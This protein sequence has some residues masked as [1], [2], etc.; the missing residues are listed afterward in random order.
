MMMVI[1][2]T[3]QVVLIRI[4]FGRSGQVKSL[5]CDMYWPLLNGMQKICD[6][7]RGG[8]ILGGL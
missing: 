8:F 2:A 4:V 1:L 7:G 6:L 5:N 3:F